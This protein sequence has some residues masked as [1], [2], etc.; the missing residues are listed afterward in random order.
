MSSTST[1]SLLRLT[2]VEGVGP[3]LGRRLLETFGSAEAALAASPGDLERVEGIG[4]TRA[5]RIHASM[6]DS[7]AALD[8]ELALAQS[9]NVRVVALGD[10]SY[11]P[12]L[13]P[14]ADA[15]LV[16]YH[17]GPAPCPHTDFPVAIVGSRHCTA[18][19][20]EQ[21]ERFAT[22]LAQ[23][24]LTI[25]SGGARGV[26]S[27]AHRATLRAGPTAAPTVAVLGCGLANCYP[28]ENRDLFDEIVAAGGSIVSELP[29]ATAPSAE[30]FPARNRII[31]GL[32]LGILVIEA[33]RGSGA[34]IT[35]RL[36]IDDYNREVLAIPGR[37]DSRASEGSNELLRAG[38]AAMATRPSDVIDQ[39][40]AAAR[41]HA[42]GTHADRFRTPGDPEAP[43]PPTLFGPAA[44]PHRAPDPAPVPAPPPANLSPT[45]QALLDALAQPATLEE[46][47]RRTALDP[48]LIQ[49]DATILEVRRIIVRRGSTL[50]RRS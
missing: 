15:P 11:P 29:L 43:A 4:P 38:E 27:A 30:N 5:R 46:L 32:S 3:I 45:Q 7:E 42:S 37:I 44:A 26:D 25:V 35:A 48:A 40:E 50:A 28:P 23:A 1:I 24:G 39:I 6:R 47:C 17:R 31:A 36:A 12:L 21:A 49:S 34:L 18:Y 16:L 13:T 20:V 8:R 2:L 14:C 9:L 22:A 33:P 19:G 41:H 10:P